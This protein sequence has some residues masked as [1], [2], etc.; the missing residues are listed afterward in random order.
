VEDCI[1]RGPGN[2]TSDVEVKSAALLKTG[3]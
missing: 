3:M 1:D 2:N